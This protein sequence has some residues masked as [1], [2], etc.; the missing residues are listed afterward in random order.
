MK[1]LKI[2]TNANGDESVGVWF[3][4]NG[5]HWSGISGQRKNAAGTWGTNL[6][7][8][9]HE[10][11][12]T[13]LTYTRERMTIDSSGS[14]YQGYTTGGFAGGS[15]IKATGYNIKQG[16]S[17]ALGASV[18]NIDWSTGTAKL[19]IDTTNVGT[20]TLTS[21]YR[22]KQDVETQTEAGLSRIMALR[23]VTYQHTDFGTLFKADGITR[24]GFIA[25]ELQEV[26]PS[27]VEGEKDAE[28]QIQ[29]LKIDALCAVMVKAIQE[30]QAI[31]TALETR[32]SALE[33]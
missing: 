7:F 17:G 27:A 21:D 31:I 8:Y 25:H 32:L 30:Q 12:T 23:P 24:E 2:R 11:A 20:I 6:S 18:F 33:G 13:D 22:I 5:S 14:L 1:G 3:G 10:D 9:T 28:N 26:I 16:F 4:T 29:S 19:W 15:C